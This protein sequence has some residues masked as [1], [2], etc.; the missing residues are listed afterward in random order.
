MIAVTT[1]AFVLSET[2][3]GGSKVVVG[4]AVP[5]NRQRSIDDIDHS[6]WNRLL[7]KY[8]DENGMV[9][10]RGLK[11]S[12]EDTQSLQDYLS[13][14]SAANPRAK[15][16]RSARLAFWINAYNALTVH[17]ILREYPTSSIRNHT[18]KVFGYNIWKDLKL[19]V[20]G[21]PYS[22][23]DMEHKILR[24]MG[25]PRI[26]FAIV[27]A[28]ISCPRLLNEAYTADRVDKQL[29]LNARDF[30]SRSQNFQYDAGSG[31]FFL[32]SILKW[33]GGD[34]GDGQAAQLRRISRWLPTDAARRAASR[35]S[36]SVTFLEYNWGL[37]ERKRSGAPE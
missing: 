4:Q 21:Q 32:S 23:N 22:L 35:N 6:T 37:N 2:S 14:L 29:E 27:C 18:A 15:A 19:N 28:S 26:H 33:F 8:V 20:G 1:A 17:G 12:R 25:D 10:Y 16:S 24:K 31:R 11:A 13:H 34:F 36:V 30:F 7:R 3:V 9:D 5:A